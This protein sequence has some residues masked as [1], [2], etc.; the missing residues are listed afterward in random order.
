MCMCMVVCM[1]ER[2]GVGGVVEDLEF[3][4]GILVGKDGVVVFV[5]LGFVHANPLGEALA[6]FDIKVW[7]GNKV[8]PAEVQKDRGKAALRDGEIIEPVAAGTEDGGQD[9]VG[10]VEDGPPLVEA[11]GN[12]V[13]QVSA[14]QV[15]GLK[16]VRVGV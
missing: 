9:V 7:L 11:A 12:V 15:G 13:A 8:D 14:G 5:G 6:Q 16:R 3:F 10:V 2:V 4:R 1:W